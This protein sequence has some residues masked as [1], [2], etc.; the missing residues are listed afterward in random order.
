M[1]DNKNQ[2]QRPAPKPVPR[3]NEIPKPNYQDYEKRSNAFVPRR[4]AIER[5]TNIEIKPPP[6]D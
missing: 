2:N 5:N 4:E 3:P 1:P 6:A